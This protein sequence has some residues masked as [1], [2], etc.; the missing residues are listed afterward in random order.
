MVVQAA[1]ATDVK[2][3]TRMPGLA[4]TTERVVPMP[5]SPAMEMS[6]ARRRTR[7]RDHLDGVR[8]LQW[9]SAAPERAGDAS[10]RHL[11]CVPATTACRPAGFRSISRSR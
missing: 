8:A 10:S 3:T 7:L 11:V 2:A 9:L 1:A 4:A 5:S 6:T